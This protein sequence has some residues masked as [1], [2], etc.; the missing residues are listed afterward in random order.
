MF[1]LFDPQNTFAAL[2]RAWNEFN[3]YHF[4][5]TD[6]PQDSVLSLSYFEAQLRA[7]IIIRSLTKGGHKERLMI[8]PC[9]CRLSRPQVAVFR[10]LLFPYNCNIGATLNIQCKIR[11]YAYDSGFI[12]NLKKW[13][14]CHLDCKHTLASVKT[15]T[16]MRQ[17]NQ[18]VFHPRD[19]A[20]FSI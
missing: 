12:E 7:K 6:P 17:R 20:N 8:K 15:I 1:S 14:R 2:C 5:L 18:Q 16:W 13:C 3:T 10:P 4:L 9:D 11:L 19:L